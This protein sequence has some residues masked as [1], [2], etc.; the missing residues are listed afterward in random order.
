MGLSEAK[1]VEL[2]YDEQRAVIGMKFVSEENDGASKIRIRNSACVFSARGFLGYNRINIESTS[3]YSIS[4]DEES[5][6]YVIDL[7]KK[8]P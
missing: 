6:L 1:Y 5:G 3:T 2:Y 4:K 8:E 7:S